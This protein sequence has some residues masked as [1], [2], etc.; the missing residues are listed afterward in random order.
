MATRACGIR[1][2]ATPWIHKP[3][4]ELPGPKYRQWGIRSSRSG[5]SGPAQCPAIEL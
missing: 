2:G 5:E 4:A 3:V 1:V